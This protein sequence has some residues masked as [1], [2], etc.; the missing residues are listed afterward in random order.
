MND[1]HSFAQPQGL[2]QQQQ[3]GQGMRQ[4]SQMQYT[5]EQFEPLN[6]QYAMAAGNDNS[7]ANV[8]SSADGPNRYVIVNG[9]AMAI[10][11]HV[12]NNPEHL[13]RLQKQLQ[14]QQ[15]S[16]GQPSQGVAILSLNQLPPQLQQQVLLQQQQQQQQQQQFS[17]SSSS[18]DNGAN[19]DS[20]SKN[21]SSSQQ[22]QQQQLWQQ[23]RQQQLQQ[24]L[25]HQHGTTKTQQ[26]IAKP[27]QQQQ[28]LINGLN[29]AQLQALVNS[30]QLDANLFQQLIAAS[31]N[32]TNSSAGGDN[33]NVPGEDNNNSDDSFGDLFTNPF[34]DDDENDSNSNSVHN[35]NTNNSGGGGMVNDANGLHQKLFLETQV[36]PVHRKKGSFNSLSNEDDLFKFFEVEM[37]GGGDNN[38]S[39]N[40]NNASGA[41]VRISVRNLQIS[42]IPCT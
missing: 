5:Q 37:G 13:Q 34:D 33:S 39:A 2:A 31:N 27:P 17:N 40:A 16:S 6:R 7:K 42:L 23:M 14:Q 12:L 30:G 35:Q 11:A 32:N 38:S 29:M 4:A 9:V 20:T 8:I 1:Q 25:Q 24:Q 28:L 26:H 41:V 19:N 3:Q 18:N 36:Q 10:P 22:Q 15:A 21:D